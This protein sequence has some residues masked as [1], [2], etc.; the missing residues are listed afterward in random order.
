MIT[1]ITTSYVVQI[2]SNGE[3]RDLIKGFADDG[4]RVNPIAIESCEAHRNEG[5][6]ARIML[7][8]VT[9]VTEDISI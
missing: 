4:V 9:A 3:W 2:W 6:E 7:R 5:R 8:R 1:K